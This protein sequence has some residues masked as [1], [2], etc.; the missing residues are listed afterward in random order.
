MVESEFIVARGFSPDG[1]R[2]SPVF[3]ESKAGP[4]RDPSG[5]NPLTTINPHSTGNSFSSDNPW[6]QVK[7]GSPSLFPQGDVSALRGFARRG[8]VVVDQLRDHRVGVSQ[9]LIVDIGGERG[10]LR[11][12]LGQ[13]R[14]ALVVQVHFNVGRQTDP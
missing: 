5:I 7:P 14:A 8:A 4:L 3:S 2:S 1:L 9:L 6:P 11:W 10:L 12:L 13:H